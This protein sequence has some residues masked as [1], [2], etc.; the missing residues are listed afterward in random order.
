MCGIAG[1]VNFNGEPAAQ[2]ILKKMT[3][4]IAHR[5][6]DGEGHFVERHVGI[7]HRRLAV[8]DITPSAHQ[9]MMTRDGRYIISFNGEIYNYR[10]L[11]LE[12]QSLGYEFHSKSDTEV[13]LNAYVEWREKCLEKLNGMFALVIYDKAEKKLF[14]ARDKYGIKP[15]YYFF[16]VNSFLFGSEQK[17]ILAHPS[18][19]KEIDLEGLLEYFTFQ[20]FFTDKTLLCGLKLFPAGCYAFLNYQGNFQMYKYWDYD[21][22]EPEIQASEEEYAEELDRLM[23]Q[24]VS[25]QLIGDVEIGAFLSG[26]MD[27]G[28]IVALASRLMP[29]MKTFTC[30]F[31]LTSASGLELAFD[32]RSR[33]EY[34]SYLFKTEHYQ[35]VLKSGD[36]ERIMTKVAVQIEEPRVGQSYPNYYVAQ[37]ASKFVNVVLCGSGGDELFG[38]YPWRYQ[39]VLN[40][41]DFESYIDTYYKYWQRLIPNTTLQKLFLPVQKNVKHI[42]TRDIMR[43][44]FPRSRRAPVSVEDCVNNSL[45]FEAKTFLQ[46]LLI[47]DDKLMAAHTVE[48]RLPFLDNDVVDFAMK[49][50][51]SLKVKNI[52]MHVG[53]D[54]NDL[55]AKSNFRKSNNGKYLLRSVMSKYIPESISNA[56]K[57]GFSA[58]D[59]SWFKGDSIEYVKRK[60]WDDKSPLYEYLDKEVVRSIVG[61]HLRG[62]HN[63]RLFIWSML[64]VGE[65]MKETLLT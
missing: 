8:I 12:L 28:S 53:L 54:E 9:P 34:M 65:W 16:A 18:S 6:R 1:Y 46:G 44:V 48:G 31:D 5:G 62:E 61:E 56:D 50:P 19:R 49:I 23:R 51:V 42:V 33:A 37:L 30:G 20:N 43:D 4:A 64:S 3:D 15:L 36:M 55:A 35:M 11:R 13:L 22:C 63:R 2:V 21:F 47:V 27:S 57:Q 29:N 58:P 14:I 59:A 41:L 60:L 7:G 52:N 45:Y 17:A 24:A 40:C 38:G 32:E 39:Q 25:R 10:E 26:G